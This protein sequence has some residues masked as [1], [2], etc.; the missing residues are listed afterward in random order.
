M[1]VTR[2]MTQ[3]TK[4][5]TDQDFTEFNG[6][7]T[8]PKWAGTADVNYKVGAWSVN[9]GVD[10]VGAQKSYDLLGLTPADG[11]KLDVP[12]YFV[13][14]LSVQYK[15]D[16]NLTVTAGIRNLFD[17]V[18]P[19]IS[20]ANG[21]YDRVGNAPLYSEYDYYGRRVFVNVAKEF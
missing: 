12:D 18:P 11:F 4:N 3:A 10:W 6:T 20:G 17:K 1:Q 9:Y 13:H 19:F 14:R 5:F 16:N 8:Q 2:Y 7:L 15:T 21:F